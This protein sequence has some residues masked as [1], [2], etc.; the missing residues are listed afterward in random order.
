MF[1]G[2]SR[3]E[4]VNPIAK[5]ASESQRDRSAGDRPDRMSGGSN[6]ASRKLIPHA[7]LVFVFHGL[8]QEC[9]GHS[10]I[11][12]GR[13]AK[14]DVMPNSMVEARSSESIHA[15]PRARNSSGSANVTYS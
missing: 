15:A 13:S 12:P 8:T 9:R 2:N 4:P 3:A 14:P 6:A 7:N 5:H 10:E 1:S 11:K